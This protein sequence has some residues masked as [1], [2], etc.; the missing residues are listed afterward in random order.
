MMPASVFAHNRY[1]KHT[2]VE[3]DKENLER[4][5]ETSLRVPGTIVSLTGPSKAGKSMLVKRVAIRDADI[6]SIAEVNGANIEQPSDIWDQALNNLNIATTSEEH[7]EVEDGETKR[8]GGGVNFV[9]QVGG[10]Q[11]D[12]FVER[13][14]DIAK[15]ER[16][17]MN[18]LID[19]VNLDEFVLL[20][21]DFHYISPDIRKDIAQKIKA[22]QQE[23]ISVCVALIN[24]RREIL[25]K[26]N[27]DLS[28]RV[29]SLEVDY[30]DESDLI[31]IP[32]K[33]FS[34]LKVDVPD[35]LLNTLVKESAG[36][37]QLMQ[38]LCLCTCIAHNLGGKD[39]QTLTQEDINEEAIFQEAMDWA[40]YQTVIEEI[41]DG[42]TPRGGGRSSYQIEDGEGDY[43]TCCLKAIAKDPPKFELSATKLYNRVKD[44]CEDS[45]PQ[46]N[47]VYL[48]G[49][50]IEKIVE[51]EREDGIVKWDDEVEE[52]EEVL[53]ISEPLFLFNI[54]CADRL[55]SF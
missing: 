1:P 13:S 41:N 7:S 49:E 50:N 25:E 42:L 10:E 6:Q 28:G 48:F 22:A 18:K 24:Y 29:R 14:I 36:S 19:S 40:G 4:K 15:D 52:E 9:G 20:I 2:Y 44:I 55:S 23:G 35:N 46:S 3:R 12:V 32:K 27:D 54:R 37:P 21:D 33:G 8:V 16:R 53:N 45:H 5:L 17:D 51:R 26:L 43:Y 34:K 30:W 47:Q 39:E 11:E 38:L 31:Q